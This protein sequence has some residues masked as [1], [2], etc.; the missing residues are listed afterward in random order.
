MYNWECFSNNLAC[1][2]HKAKSNLFAKVENIESNK[3]VFSSKYEYQIVDGVPDLRNTISV[4]C[5]SRYTEIHG[6]VGG[7]TAGKIHDVDRYIRQLNLKKQQ[8]RKKTI[9]LAGAGSGTE[10]DLLLRY[11]PELVVAI[12][13]R[14]NVRFLAKTYKSNQKTIFFQ[15]DIQNLPFKNSVFDMSF[16]SG[17]FSTVRSPE[18]GFREMLYSTKPGG[19]ISIGGIYKYNE[20]HQLIEKARLKHEFHKMDY[21]QAVNKLSK[22]IKRRLRIRKIHHF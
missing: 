20:K 1:P 4:Y 6:Y 10:L 19:T 7:N 2:R 13:Y 18:L 5:S 12:D 8:I 15:A 9:L 3:I 22:I 11:D 17:V 14:D 21:Q 16:N